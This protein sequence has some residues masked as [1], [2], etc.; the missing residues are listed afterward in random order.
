MPFK[1]IRPIVQGAIAALFCALLLSAPVKAA[2]VNEMSEDELKQFIQ[3]YL[4]ANPEVIIDSLEQFQQRQ[5]DIT[6]QYQ[7]QALNG[8][9]AQANASENFP[10]MGPEDA[11]VTIIEFF[12]YQCGYCKRAFPDMMSL[13]EDDGNI[14]VI[15]VELPILGPASKLAALAALAADR[16]GKYVEFHTEVMGSRGQLT[17][18]KVFDVAEDLD[19]DLT[20]LK[21]DMKDEGIQT[22]LNGNLQAAEMLG[23]GGTPAFIIGNELFP[24]AIPKA[25]M[26]AAVENTRDQNS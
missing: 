6:S 2:G 22:L 1:K 26:E 7:A 12:D 4:M 20:Q 18:E 14:R 23:I 25:Q 15:F 13:V 10:T 8:F 3:E 9:I 24:G 16:Q 17:Q 11:D 5:E 19:L 21:A